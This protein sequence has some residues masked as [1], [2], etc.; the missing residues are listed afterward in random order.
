MNARYHSCLLY[1]SRAYEDDGSLVARSKA[2]S[3]ITDSDEAVK[4]VLKMI[5]ENKVHTMSGK[6]IYIKADSVCVHGDGENA[7]VFTQKL[8][9]AFRE[10]NIEIKAF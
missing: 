1:T 3:M 2:G 10:N 7:L 9:S 5:C 6:E 8:C 4:R